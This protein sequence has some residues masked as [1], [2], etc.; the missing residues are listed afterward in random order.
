MYIAIDIIILAVMAGA[1]ISAARRGLIL[2]LFKLLSAV[3][4]LIVAL[5]FY[6]EL[7]AFF[8]DM[9]VYDYTVKHVE[10]FVSEIAQKAAEPLTH[11]MLLEALPENVQNAVELLNID[12]GKIVESVAGQPLPIAERLASELADILS[13]VIA[14]ATIF[15]ISL[16]GLSVLGYFLDKL[17]KLPVIKETNKVLGFVF[18]IIEAIILG[19]VLSNLAASFCS[20]YGAFDPDFAFTSVAEKTY[21]ARLFLSIY[22]W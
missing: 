17:A 2:T 6:K 5:M 13:G 12:L 11:E 9:F 4:S 1:I 21:V 15:F 20:S 18:G 14:F 19:F 3:A 10:R 8:Y 16:I 7:G 22:S